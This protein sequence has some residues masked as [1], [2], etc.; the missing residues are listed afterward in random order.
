[1][2]AVVRPRTLTEQWHALSICVA[3]DAIVIMQ[4]ANTGLTGG[5]TPDGD[6]YDRPVVIISATRITGVYLI[7]GGRQAICFP[8]TTLYELE[9][10][11]KAVGR[12]PHSV[13]GSS[14]IGASV[15]GGVSNNS[16]GSLIARGPAYTE[17]ALF[18]RVDLNGTLL[19]VNHL[20]INLEG[21]PVSML[22]R[23][24]RRDLRGSDIHNE[25][26]GKAHASDYIHH[27]REVDSPTPAR[28]NADPR[29]LYEAS[30]CAGRLALFAV[31]LDTFPKEQG[32]TVFYIGTNRTSDLGEL[33][34][35]V[36]GRF[37]TL[38]IA[39]EYLHREAFNIAEK[40]GKDTFLAIRCLG[41]H[42]LPYLFK[43]KEFLDTWTR[44]MGM[45]AGFS[46]RVLQR[47]SSVFPS[48]LPSRMRNFRDRY[49]HHLLLKVSAGGIGEMREY[50]SKSMRSDVADFFECSPEE[51]EKAFLHRFATAGAAMRYAAVHS[52]EGIVALDVALPRNAKIWEECLPPEIERSILQKLYYGHFF[53]F[54]FHQDYI[55]AKGH[56]PVNLE[57]AMW[58]LL[59]QRGAEYPAE[60][61]VGHLYKAKP[62]LVA[63]YKSL[64]PRNQLNP[65]LGQTSKARN[66][67]L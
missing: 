52:T 17:L 25:S 67:G 14:C 63:F 56:D 2:A 66:W 65:G 20:D 3:A 54:V 60:H 36:L 43:A 28:F 35:E 13:I 58:K 1:V 53:C 7:D 55:V 38:P 12:E 10:T 30:G 41:T 9:R 23:L 31:R 47:L 21:D 37:K 46:D 27:I 45:R 18:A 22:S 33:R 62:S 19:L 34:R 57:H 11:L 5:S 6:K 50:L 64:D 16:G 15:V 29:R 40:Y 32:S 48:H 61:N 44:S 8:G 51:G 42:H 26:N 39:G 59:D 24:D 4:A 49:E